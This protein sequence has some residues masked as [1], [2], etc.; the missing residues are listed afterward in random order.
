MQTFLGEDAGFERIFFFSDD[1]PAVNG[2][3]THPSRANLL[4]VLRQVFETPFMGAGDNFWFFFS[5]HGIRHQERDYLLPADGD[6]EDIE[7][8]AISITYITER[9]RRCGADN[10]VLILDACRNQS[11]RDGQGIGYETAEIARQAGVVS[12]FSCSPNEYSYE[13]EELQQ[14]IFTHTLLEGLGTQGHCATV[15]SLDH[16][17]IN[18]VPELSQ[19][20][21]KPRQTPYT[22]AEPLTKQHLILLPQH[23]TSSDV[24]TLK[25]DA[26]RAAQMTGNL[27]LSEQL[28]IR[29]LAASSGR[30]MEAIKAL[31]RIAQLRM[32]EERPTAAL[33]VQ[34]KAGSVSVGGVSVLTPPAQTIASLEWIDDNPTQPHETRSPA[35]PRLPLHWKTRTHDWT[36]ILTGH[37]ADVQAIAISANGHYLA[38]GSHDQTARL[39]DLHSGALLQTYQGHSNLVTVVTFTADNHRLISG[40]GDNTIKLWDCKTGA[41]TGTLTGHSGWVLAIA[42]TPDGKTLVSGSA[43]GS[44][45]LWN[46]ETQQERSTFNGH[47]GWVRSVAL[48]TDGKLLVSGSHDQTI[49][50]WHLETGDLLHT[51]V[52]HTDLVHFVAISPDGQL[53]VSASHDQTIR[54]WHLR[55]RKL[56]RTLTRQNGGIGAIALSADGKLLASS[57]DQTIELWHLNKGKRFRKLT[58]HVKRVSAIAFNA[59]GKLLVSG[60]CDRTIRVWRTQVGQ[61]WTKVLLVSTALLL[62]VGGISL[63]RQLYDYC[64]PQDSLTVCLLQHPFVKTAHDQIFGKSSHLP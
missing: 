17:L 43:D 53:L 46:L 8:T 49:K 50:L 11:S 32:S 20:Y 44:I 42:P 22:I 21:G 64:E 25:N 54:L 48:S 28:W 40:S 10:I 26:Y 45:K 19:H 37:T 16:Y 15:E 39:W 23:A 55:K 7:N 57:Y 3:S 51:F 14:G 36:H 60:S 56:L 41:L 5:G 24:A 58:G 2:K 61:I 9:L 30:D 12:I 59:D 34:E 52:G 29:V 13:V 4:R 27:E 62:G 47:L 1:S 31:Q 63:Y 33:S 38:S 6:P 35:L 18:R